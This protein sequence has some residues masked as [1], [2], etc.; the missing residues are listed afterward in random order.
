MEDLSSIILGAGLLVAGV[1]TLCSAYRRT[2]QRNIDLHPPKV[3]YFRFDL[4]SLLAARADARR[5][6]EDRNPRL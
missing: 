3:L 2:G 5:S 1:L 6:L 4:R